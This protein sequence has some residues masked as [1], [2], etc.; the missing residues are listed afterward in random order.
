MTRLARMVLSVVTSL[1]PRAARRRYQ[2]ELDAEMLDVPPASRV[3][4]AVSLLGSVPRLR[5]EVLSGLSGGR[6]S[7]R[8]YL[9]WH[10]KR[11]VHPNPEDHTI[12]ALQC[13]RC[14]HVRD[15]RQYLR[16]SN[17]DGVAWGG[18]YL[19]GGRNAGW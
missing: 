13:R 9:G 15:P 12:I 1:L 2:E 16:S 18:V 17:A 14:G 10:G 8:C 19:S 6:P 11:V 7:V 4:F 3:P 5:W